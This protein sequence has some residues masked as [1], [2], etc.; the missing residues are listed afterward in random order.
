MDA[1]IGSIRILVLYDV[2]EQI[3]LDKLREILGAEPPSRAP[4]FKHPAPEYVRFEHPPV[5]EDPGPASLATGEQFETRIKYFD[6]GVV[7]VE[8]EMRFETDWEGLVH[9]SNRWTSTPELETRTAEIVRARLDRARPALVQPYKSWLNEDYYVIHITK[10]VDDS[11]SPAAAH[12]MLSARSQQIAQIVRGESVPL[13]EAECRE[14]LQSSISYYPN[15]LLV[16]GW[17]AAFVYDTPEGAVATIQLLEYA[18]TQLLEFRHY[19]ELLT[20]MLQH[21]YKVL[22][23]KRTGLTG[24]WRM[25]RQAEKLNAM[26][27]E[28]IELT[29][30]SDNAIKFLSD[31]FYARAYRIASNKVGVADYRNLVEQKLRIAGD[32]Y[33]F[34]V[35]AF[36]QARAFVLELMVVAILVIELIHLFRTGR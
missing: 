13:A 31:M 33:D 18:N 22:D 5:V 36:H 29:E 9:S 14:A 30:R 3:Q 12:A 20:A 34:L 11:G 8:L 21:V 6:Y 23:Q 15:D 27:L 25:A 4:S 28:V 1:L 26:R 19:D 7:C 17:T 24:R 2:A 16:V 32:L 35:N 10:A